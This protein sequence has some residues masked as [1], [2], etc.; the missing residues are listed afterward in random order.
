MMWLAWCSFC[1]LTA[2]ISDVNLSV[3]TFIYFVFRL[4]IVFYA[5]HILIMYISLNQQDIL[6]SLFSLWCNLCH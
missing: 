6:N 5:A 1:Y 3:K 4:H 2:G